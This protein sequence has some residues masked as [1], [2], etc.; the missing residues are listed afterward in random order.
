MSV[1]T[2]DFEAEEHRSTF[3]GWWRFLIGWLIA[4]LVAG[5]V[6][7]ACNFVALSIEK[8]EYSGAG[9]AKAFGALIFSVILFWPGAI[10]ITLLIA[11][12]VA[13]PIF[14][15]GGGVTVLASF[16]RPAR[17]WIFWTSVAVGFALVF[18]PWLDGRFVNPLPSTS[19]T[20]RAICVALAGSTTLWFVARFSLLRE[21]V[22]KDRLIAAIFG[23][24]IIS[25]SLVWRG[26]Y[27]S[28]HR[29]Q[30]RGAGIVRNAESETASIKLLEYVND[31]EARSG[32]LTTG[33]SLTFTFPKQFE[34]ALDTAVRDDN[35]LSIETRL[36]DFAPGPF[37]MGETGAKR[38]TIRVSAANKLASPNFGSRFNLIVEW[39]PEKEVGA[40]CGLRFA[41]ERLQKYDLEQIKE[42]WPRSFAQR[43]VS[44]VGA[45]LPNS[46]EVTG[47]SCI[48]PIGCQ[49]SFAYQGFDASYW[50]ER[51]NLC[52]WP[53]QTDRVRRFLDSN[54]VSVT[55][56]R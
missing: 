37:P 44:L 45:A 25:V 40:I 21:K 16:W 28:Q 34:N 26:T 22:T 55:K 9:L 51:R 35:I 32:F 15:V 20:I 14:V 13:I 50:I 29:W 27:P 11:C 10:V 4:S 12:I 48:T 24:L 43:N 56:A 38:S 5:A 18:D 46:A 36:S 54:L 2:I 33:R 19:S 42:S 1:S 8:F 6:G 53:A 17:S 23:A 49:I 39:E 7:Y 41:E 52:Q 47:A 31:D 30:E 3:V